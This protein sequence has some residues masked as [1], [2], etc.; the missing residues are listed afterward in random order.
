M[1]YRFKARSAIPGAKALIQAAIA[2]V[3]DYPAE[4]DVKDS[5]AFGNASLLGEYDPITGEYTDPGAANVLV[6]HD[7]EFAGATQ[8]ALFD[9]AARNTDPTEALVFLGTNYKIQNAA[10][11][12]SFPEAARNTDPGEANVLTG[13]GYKILNVAKNGS[14]DEAARNTDPSEAKVEDGTGYKILNVAK[15]GIY[16]TTAASKA[17]QLAEDIAAV[18]A[19]KASILNTA[20]ILTVTGTYVPDVGVTMVLE[21]V[22]MALEDVP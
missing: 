12:G 14:F 18:D 5:V 9:E 7:Y 11:V 22:D 15:T 16:P 19:E 13:T 20:T 10:K 17:V 6:G 1:A 4:A 21:D 8:T 2:V 3:A